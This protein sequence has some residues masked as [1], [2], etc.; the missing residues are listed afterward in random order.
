MPSARRDLRSALQERV[1]LSERPQ[2]VET[3]GERTLPGAKMVA[4]TRVK[5][6]PQQ[7]RKHFESQ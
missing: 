2:I 3:P 7:P 4:I 5:P 6:N 1:V